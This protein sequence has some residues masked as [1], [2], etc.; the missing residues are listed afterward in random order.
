MRNLNRM[1]NYWNRVA[2]WR[3]WKKLADYAIEHGH[4]ELVLQTT[5][6]DNA[7]WRKIDQCI[8]ELKR[9]LAKA[10][11]TTATIIGHV[12]YN[13]DGSRDYWFEWA[14]DPDG[15]ALVNHVIE[16]ALYENAAFGQLPS[17][18]NLPWKMV[19]IGNTR[20]TSIYKRED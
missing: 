3:D 1:L 6:A 19:K 11:I 7:T 17:W 14:G 5:P 12:T 15:L 20:D 18:V 2:A 4:R 13:E 8:E 16:R 9:L 10:G